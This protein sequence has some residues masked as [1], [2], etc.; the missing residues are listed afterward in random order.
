[1]YNA[2]SFGSVMYTLHEVL[3]ANTLKTAL[4]FYFIHFINYWSD[5]RSIYDTEDQLYNKKSSLD[6]IFDV[7]WDLRRTTLD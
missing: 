2:A 7:R 1:M 5:V 4:R 3:N 6:S